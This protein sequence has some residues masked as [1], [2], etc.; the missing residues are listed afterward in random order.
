[1]RILNLL[2]ARKATKVTEVSMPVLPLIFIDVIDTLE[3]DMRSS[4]NTAN[5]S[6]VRTEFGDEDD[7]SAAMTISSIGY[8]NVMANGVSFRVK[9]EW[10]AMCGSDDAVM[11]GVEEVMSFDVAGNKQVR[12]T[13]QAQLAMLNA[14]TKQLQGAEYTNNPMTAAQD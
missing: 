2:F 4:I 11:T 8:F 13:P 12:V 14:V 7:M 10:W 5:F 6:L 9:A 3:F 1:M